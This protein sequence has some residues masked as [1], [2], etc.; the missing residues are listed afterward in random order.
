MRCDSGLGL[1]FSVPPLPVWMFCSGG[2]KRPVPQRCSLASVW[3]DSY[4]PV[5]CNL[6]GSSVHVIPQ[7]RI[8]EW[9][10]ISFPS[11]SSP[12]RG[13]TWVSC[14]SYIGRRVVL[15]GFSLDLELPPQ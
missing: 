4:H 6:L 15:C 14:I 9:V 2:Q 3:S 12:P 13:R 1:V 8:M 5:D 11:G 10:A 7:S